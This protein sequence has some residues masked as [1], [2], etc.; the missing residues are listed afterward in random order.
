MDEPIWRMHAEDGMPVTDIDRELHLARG[1]AH[2]TIVAH[3]R[4]DKE[5]GRP[6]ARIREGE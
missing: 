3:W 4:W 6:A 1:T 2:D 5:N